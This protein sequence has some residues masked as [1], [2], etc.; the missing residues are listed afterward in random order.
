MIR[1]VVSHF[2]F[3]S[4]GQA[5]G[6]L[7]RS[8]A[9]KNLFIALFVTRQ[10]VV[11]LSNRRHVDFIALYIETYPQTTEESCFGS[12]DPTIVP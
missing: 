4:T 1:T 7:V 5:S 2:L 6:T 9:K 3:S 12:M 11:R 8:F 10:R